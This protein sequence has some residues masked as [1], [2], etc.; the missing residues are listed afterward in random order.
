MVTLIPIT[1]PPTY[2]W[3][4]HCRA[5]RDCTVTIGTTDWHAIPIGVCRVCEHI[6]YEPTTRPRNAIPHRALLAT[7]LR[8]FSD[9]A[10]GELGRARV[11]LPV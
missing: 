8:P 3:C 10:G 6:V 1:L 11:A 2:G 7:G 5:V 9:S 4:C